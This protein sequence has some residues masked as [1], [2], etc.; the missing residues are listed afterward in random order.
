[1]K[2]ANP[3]DFTQNEARN[4]ALHKLASAPGSPVEAQQ[5]YN[6]SGKVPYFWNGATWRP[7]DAA[8]LTDGS[9]QNS[10]LATNPLARANHTGTQLSTTISDLAATVKA[11]RL[12]EFAAP[13]SNI[14]MGGQRITSVSDPSSASDV[15]TKN[16]VDAAV[17][18]AAAG[19]DSKPSVRAIATSNITLSGTQTIDGVALV[20]DNRV[21][22][23]GQTTASQN[24]VYNVSA[25][26]WTRA[27]D[28]NNT[29]EITPGAFWFVEEGT[30]YGKTQWRC[31][32]AG[33]ITIG[34]TSITIVQFGASSM[35]SANANTM[36]LTGVEFAVKIDGSGWLTSSGSGLA[37]DKTK[38]PGKYP[39]QITGDA[40][41]VSYNVDHN[42][43][44]LD[45]IVQVRDASGNQVLVD[46]QATTVNRV[47]LTYA[48]ALGVGVNHRVI[49]HG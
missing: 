24:G 7:M 18:S 44:T 20:A 27:S 13:T 34:S 6:T 11:Y 38:V 1:M 16:Y 46:N 26:S 23:A 48:A 22:V 30:T 29:G 43:N 12:D 3:L 5:Y 41:T 25:G 17:D 42:L 36:T 19:I 9:I 10:A 32:N 47:V 39:A 2:I 15:A 45:V 4:V 14:S 8:A 37:V 49:V 33:T 35:Y 28:A 31:N 21:L 40:S